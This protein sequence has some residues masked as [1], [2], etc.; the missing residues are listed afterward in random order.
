MTPEERIEALGL[1]LPVVAQPVGNYVPALVDGACVWTS[2]QLPLVEGRL[3]A[4]GS[5]GD[6]DGLV[7]PDLARECARI[8]ALN[9]LAAMAGSCGGLDRILRVVRV[10]GYVASAPGFTAQP[11]VVNG[12]SDLMVEVFGE[13]GRHVRSAIGVTALP[14]GSPVEIEI[15]ARLR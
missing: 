13:P 8:A 5:V 9:G 1:S 2:G 12:A 6:D 10:V 14:L 15:E 3:A 7:S 4:T 11:S